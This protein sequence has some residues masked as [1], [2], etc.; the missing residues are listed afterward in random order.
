MI[1]PIS[2]SPSSPTANPVSRRAWTLCIAETH[3]CTAAIAHTCALNWILAVNKLETELASAGVPVPAPATVATAVKGKGKAA[4]AVAAAPI[5]K[6]PETFVDYWSPAM[7]VPEGHA[8][9]VC[10]CMC[11]C[12]CVVV[13]GEAGFSGGGG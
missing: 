13:V 12:V 4:G 1:S 8:F 9:E 10:V 11:V 3:V 5:P 7:V 6:E 2:P